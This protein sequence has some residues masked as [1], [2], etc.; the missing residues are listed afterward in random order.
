M[1]LIEELQTMQRQNDPGRRREMLSA[2]ADLFFD[3]AE[4]YSDRLL[5]QYSDVL[6]DLLQRVDPETRAEIADRIADAP[7]ASQ[8]LHLFLAQAELDVAAP[9]LRRSRHLGDEALV[10]IA[11]RK[12]EGHRL[13]IAMREH[14]SEAVTDVLVEFGEPTVLQAVTLN[15]GAEISELSF[16]RLAQFAEDDEDL[17]EAMSH[18]PDLP[19][20]AADRILRLLPA[21]ARSRLATLLAA[22]RDSVRPLLSQAAWVAR[23]QRLD[24]AL[25]R[26]EAKGLIR[27]IAEGELPRDVV[28]KWLAGKDRVLDLALVFAELADFRE[29]VMAS[30][31]L[32]ADNGPLVVLIRSLDISEDA[33]RS[34][35]MM[36]CR[37]LALPLSAR[38]QLLARWKAI[39]P[40]TA[41]RAM[42]FTRLRAAHGAA[43]AA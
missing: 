26:L 19:R 23:Q 6:T 12:T 10:E 41:K 5:V 20:A 9:V 29:S 21:E 2:F 39:Q 27:Q 40:D 24:R 22:D 7:H 36:R 38:D 17:L 28:V 31:L 42:R 4:H 34:I 33:V 14:L 8:A 13:A 3:S 43:A 32:K 11:T 35:A 30:C 15:L 37:R 1:N 16:G 18:R 25:E